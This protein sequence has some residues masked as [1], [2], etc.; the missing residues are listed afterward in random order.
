LVFGLL[1]AAPI[2]VTDV[3]LPPG[4]DMKPGV[5]EQREAYINERYGLD[6]P[7]PV[8]Y[9]RWLNNA[10]PVGLQVWKFDEPDVIEARAQRRE[11]RTAREEELKASRPGLAGDELRGVIDAAEEEAVERGEVNFK[12]R[13]GQFRF[14]RVPLKMPDLGDSYIHQRPA[15][16][17]ILS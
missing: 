15:H 17:L 12:P 4:G 3:L 7:F 11:W 9:F 10:S 14:D 13:P 2:K 5:R 6:D 1:A 16:E 8:R